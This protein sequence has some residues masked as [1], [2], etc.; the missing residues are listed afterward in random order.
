MKIAHLLRSAATVIGAIV[1]AGLSVDAAAQPT[2]P[3][4][5]SDSGVLQE[6]VVTA[7]KRETTL[8]KTAVA[9]TAVS[10]DDLRK[11]GVADVTSLQKVAPEVNITNSSAGPTI[12]VRG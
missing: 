12:N 2:Q 11:N 6:V 9:V 3:Q 4:S 1:F 8:Q 5:S 10:Q 7:E